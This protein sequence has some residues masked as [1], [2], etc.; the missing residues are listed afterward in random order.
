MWALL[1]SCT[2]PEVPAGNQI[3]LHESYEGVDPTCITSI[4]CFNTYY[5]YFDEVTIMCYFECVLPP[6][7]LV[8]DQGQINVSYKYQRNSNG[9]LSL[10]SRTIYTD[11]CEEW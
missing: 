1:F 9:C 3:G 10:R 5:A 11:S 2:L 4:A 7:D 6:D 8:D